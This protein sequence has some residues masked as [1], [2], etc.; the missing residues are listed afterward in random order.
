MSAGG[1]IVEPQADNIILTPI[2]AHNLQPRSL[3]AS[4]QRKVDLRWYED[5]TVVERCFE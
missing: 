5:G 1:P 4:P 2:C 3:I